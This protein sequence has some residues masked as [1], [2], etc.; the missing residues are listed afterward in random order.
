MPLV[1]A[2]PSPAPPTGRDWP[3]WGWPALAAAALVSVLASA[4]RLFAADE[5]LL[6]TG[7]VN[8]DAF[9]FAQWARHVAA[10]NGPSF[11]G[12]EYTDGVRPI[13]ALTLVPIYALVSDGALAIRL[14]GI[15]GALVH[16]AAV[17]LLARALARALR[18]AAVIAVAAVGML[19]PTM[20]SLSAGVM[21]WPMNAL[22]MVALCVSVCALARRSAELPGGPTWAAFGAGVL[23]ALNLLQR[24]ETL[25]LVVA[26]GVLLARAWGAGSRRAWCWLLGGGAA[27]LV[28]FAIA[29]QVLYGAF[30]SVAG[31]LKTRL[32]VELWS[33]ETVG[34]AF[35]TVLRQ[36]PGDLLRDLGAPA[37]LRAEGAPALVALAWVVVLV[38]AAAAL[39]RRRP[40]QRAFDSGDH[41]ARRVRH[42]V[43]WPLVLYGLVHS[44]TLAAL[45]HPYLAYGRWYFAPQDLALLVLL[46]LAADGAA[47]RLPRPLAALATLVFVG[48]AL[49]AQARQGLGP[50]GTPIEGHRVLL[51]AAAWLADEV[52]ADARVGAHNAGVLAYYA[53]QPVTNLDGLMNTH[54]FARECLLE[55]DP[56]RRRAN[57]LR[58]LVERDIQWLADPWPRELEQHLPAVFFGEAARPFF[59]LEVAL[60]MGGR[61]T[62]SYQIYRLDTEALGALLR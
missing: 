26:L 6:V 27:V 37:I 53:R 13:W 43:I 38:L 14:C 1:A 22:L 45:L 29:S 35:V 2:V 50:P 16:V 21:D 59:T 32:A 55:P 15:W 9:Y 42:F 34:T 54:T 30:G 8:D 61:P 7:F 4:A 60:P 48:A 24:P 62:E 10:G 52:P 40:A 18:P 25:P 33:P 51:E 11:D 58:Y 12:F 39:A 31:G 46:A 23:G 20:T 57:L 41:E 49:L 17:A 44:V 56:E 47:R 5:A 28:P 3:R 36:S 19:A